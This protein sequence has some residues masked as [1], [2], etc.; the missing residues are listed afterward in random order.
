[1][2]AFFPACHISKWYVLVH[3]WVLQ[4][5]DYNTVINQQH[6]NASKRQSDTDI[7]RDRKIPIGTNTGTTVWQGLANVI[8]SWQ[9]GNQH[10]YKK[11]VH[12][13]RWNHNFNSILYITAYIFLTPLLNAIWK[14]IVKSAT[15]SK[16][17]TNDFAILQKSNLLTLQIS[18]VSCIY[19]DSATNPF[20]QK[21]I[22]QTFKKRQTKHS[23]YNQKWQLTK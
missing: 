16:T 4:C 21:Q 12:L 22:K 20:M 18:I 5:S 15:T 13:L 1:M 3:I 2:P 10:V 9:H 14:E 8:I 23:K 11:N 6:K 19:A 7:R 17:E